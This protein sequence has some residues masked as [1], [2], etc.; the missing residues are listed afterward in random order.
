M[1]IESVMLSNHLIL[2]TPFSFCLLSFLGSGSSPESSFHIR[3]PEYWSCSISPSNEYSGLI[4]LGMTGLIL[5]QFK[6][7][8]RVFSSTTIQKHQF[9]GTKPSLWSNSWFLKRQDI[10]LVT[11]YL[12]LYQWNTDFVFLVHLYVLGIRVILASQNK[13][14]SVPSTSAFWKSVWMFF[15]CWEEFTGFFCG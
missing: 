8:S 12:C 2:C 11:G 10:C 14:G 6:E 1:S 3:W 5:L 4:S 15:K 7:L 9:F 13:L